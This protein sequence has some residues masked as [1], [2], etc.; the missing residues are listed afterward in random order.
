MKL[1]LKPVEIP[2]F[3]QPYLNQVPDDGKLLFHL[4]EIVEETIAYVNTLSD[5]QLNYRYAPGKWTMKDILVHLS[6]C[7]RVIIYRTMR[8]ARA[9]KTNLPGFDENL[10]VDTAFAGNRAVPDILEEL[11]NY[12][13]AS[14][15]FI[16]SLSEEALDQ[17]GN[18]NGY[19]LTAR[20]LVNHLYG[21]HKH[22]LTIYRERYW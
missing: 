22:H 21:H 6:D 12:R 5:E 2:T 17:Q 3:Y 13:K 11:T 9:D 19:P 1:I 14:I 18:A 16:H 7:E 20:L 4:Q 8:I 10:F 15:S